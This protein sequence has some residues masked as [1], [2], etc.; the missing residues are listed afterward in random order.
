MKY[1]IYSDN[2]TVVVD[3]MVEYRQAVIAEVINDTVKPKRSSKRVAHI[4][5]NPKALDENG[6]NSVSSSQ[7]Q[8]IFH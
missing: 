3:G 1:S 4:T 5:K 8:T 2:T 6:R 7:R